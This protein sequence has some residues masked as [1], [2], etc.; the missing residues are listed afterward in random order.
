MELIWAAEGRPRGYYCGVAALF[1]G[2]TLDSG[3]LIRFLE[4]TSSGD[5]RYWSGGGITARSNWAEEYR[6]LSE[7]IYLP[8]RRP[9]LK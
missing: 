7:K 6:E 8:Q 9:V 2:E 3:V 1:D 4:Q 5:Y